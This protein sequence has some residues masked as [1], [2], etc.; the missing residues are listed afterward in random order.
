M[1]DGFVF[2]EKALS[3]NP[4]LRESVFGYNDEYLKILDELLKELYM[5]G[6]KGIEVKIHE[7]SPDLERFQATISEIEFARYFFRN[8]MDVELLSNNVFNGKRAMPPANQESI[9]LK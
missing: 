1:R 3:T 9:M 8:Q 6:C 7:T 5:N 2:L 4:E